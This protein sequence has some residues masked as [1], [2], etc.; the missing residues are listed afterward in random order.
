MSIDQNNPAENRADCEQ[1]KPGRQQWISPRLESLDL[2]DAK[3]GA[4][5]GGDVATS[6]S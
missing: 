2:R 6:H 1:Q 4:G 5:A 3:T